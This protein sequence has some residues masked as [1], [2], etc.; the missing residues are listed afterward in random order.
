MYC[1][2]VFCETTKCKY[3]AETLRR[4]LE[5]HTI[6]PK[7]IQHTWDKGQLI[8]IERNLLPGYIFLYSEQKLVN[9]IRIRSVSGVIRLLANA[10][11]SYELTGSDK[12][13]AMMLYE[14]DGCLGRT[15]V[16]EEG[17]IIKLKKGNFSGM[18]AQILKV[19][20]R[21][22][23]MKIEIPFTSMKLKTWVEYEIE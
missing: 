4:I 6:Y 14:N 16:Y 18:H 19:D 10:D 22:K 7:Q 12:I 11:G 8:D 15:P 23:R 17:S 20:R 1:Y 21:N 9:N 5:C 3:V 13:F 2:C